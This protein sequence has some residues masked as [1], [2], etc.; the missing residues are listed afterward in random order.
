M[1]Q[2]SVD[3]EGATYSGFYSVSNGSNPLIT[4]TSEYGSDTTQVGGL[5]P[6]TLAKM[7]LLELV[8]KRLD[9]LNA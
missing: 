2:I 1:N 9:K 3:F 6:E 5:P 4:V 8:K 7:S